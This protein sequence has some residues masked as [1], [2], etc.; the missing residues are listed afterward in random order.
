[1][2]IKGN[3]CKR[4]SLQFKCEADEDCCTKLTKVSVSSL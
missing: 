1:M 2:G 4:N 3:I